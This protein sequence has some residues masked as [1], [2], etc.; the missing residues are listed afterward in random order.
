MI[1]IYKC[2]N[3]RYGVYYASDTKIVYLRECFRGGNSFDTLIGKD[4][5][6]MTLDEYYVLHPKRK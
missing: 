2:N 4:K 1:Y 5:L 3:G 6:P